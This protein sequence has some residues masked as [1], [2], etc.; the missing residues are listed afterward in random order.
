MP[1]EKY[2]FY[3]KWLYGER[4][5][6]INYSI[7]NALNQINNR[8]YHVEMR[9]QGVEK[10]F[11]DSPSCSVQNR[12]EH[13]QTNPMGLIKFLQGFGKEYR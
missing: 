11:P 8:M 6:K 3:Y 1:Y 13:V 9:G 5:V 2:Y 10:V 12:E 7:K 4:Q